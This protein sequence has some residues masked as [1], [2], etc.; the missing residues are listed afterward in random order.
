MR[1]SRALY[2]YPSGSVSSNET[3]NLSVDNCTNPVIILYRYLFP[4][5][6]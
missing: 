4:F 1:D 5:S 2:S 6:S 3:E